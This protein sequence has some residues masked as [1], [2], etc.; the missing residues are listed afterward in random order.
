MLPDFSAEIASCLTPSP[1]GMQF[2]AAC[3]AFLATIGMETNV[4]SAVRHC[5]CHAVRR[6]RGGGGEGA[7]GHTQSIHRAIG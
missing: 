2:H 7:E 3:R 6:Q 1:V 5:R 4:E